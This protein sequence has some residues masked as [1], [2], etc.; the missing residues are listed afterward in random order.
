M[1][2]DMGTYEKRRVYYMNIKHCMAIKLL[3]I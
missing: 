2:M 1:G 3:E